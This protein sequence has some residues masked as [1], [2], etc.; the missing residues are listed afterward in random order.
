[1]NV[2][3]SANKSWSDISK[4]MTDR[5]IEILDYLYCCS[6]NTQIT[7][8]TIR[9]AEKQGYTKEEVLLI[10]QKAEQKELFTDTSDLNNMLAEITGDNE[11]T[12][13]FGFYR[14]TLELT[15]ICHTRFETSGYKAKNKDYN[16]FEYLINLHNKPE[17]WKDVQQ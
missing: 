11:W 7:E 12:D 6:E 16:V 14:I 8:T 17:W 3:I 4:D 10:C 2:D 5:E 1:M 13:A 9:N 15:L